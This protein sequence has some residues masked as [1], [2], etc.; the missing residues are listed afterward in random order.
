[1]RMATPRERGGTVDSLHQRL[2][3]SV[4]GHNGALVLSF[5]FSACL[6]V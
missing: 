3:N 5:F 1:M 4:E 6:D 2:A